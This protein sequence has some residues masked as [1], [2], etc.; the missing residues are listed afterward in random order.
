MRWAYPHPLAGDGADEMDRAQMNGVVVAALA[1]AV[2]A[3]LPASPRCRLGPSTSPFRVVRR[4]LRWTVVAV[5]AA[6]CGAASTAVLLPVTTCL[7]A[8]VLVAT[9]GHRHR[10]RTRRRRH[11]DEARALATSL[12]VLVGELGVGAHPVRAFD[13]AAAEPDRTS[14]AAGLRAVAARARLGAD[15]AIGLRGVAASSSL[16]AQWERLA[17][18]WQL[19]SEHGLPISALM[20]AAQ[21]D[22]G[23][24]QRFS[25]RVNSSLAGARGSATILAA[26]PVLGVLLGQLIGAEPIRFLLN[27]TGGGLLLAGAMLVCLGLLWSDLITGR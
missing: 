12:D 15:V 5:A 9:A 19:A 8:G 23:E 20:H 10:R 18:Y 16:P 17:V 7:T 2:A 25:A 27:G 21:R 22:I 1:L 3:L 6:G 11:A 13:V 4:R 14:V 24:R 26:L